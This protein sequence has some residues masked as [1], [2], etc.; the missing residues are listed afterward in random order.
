MG[1][2]RDAGYDRPPTAE[3]AAD[4]TL[5]L[6]AKQESAPGFRSTMPTRDTQ[7]RRA[8]RATRGSFRAET[9]R[10]VETSQDTKSEDLTLRPEGASTTPNVKKQDATPP[11]P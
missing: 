4:R 11:P 5:Y 2:V 10:H 6:S 3:D 7:T 8:A 9:S 1:E